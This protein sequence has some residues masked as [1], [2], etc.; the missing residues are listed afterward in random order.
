MSTHV[1]FHGIS[2]NIFLATLASRPVLCPNGIKTQRK[3]IH[4]QRELMKL[5][6]MIKQ[7]RTNLASRGLFVQ[8][9]EH[10]FGLFRNSMKPTGGPIAACT[11]LAM[12]RKGQISLNICGCY[13]FERELNEAEKI[14]LKK[15]IKF[16]NYSVPAEVDT[17]FAYFLIFNLDTFFNLGAGPG[18]STYEISGP[19]YP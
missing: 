3:F 9:Y 1:R 13:W 17:V 16:Q 19:E 7:M 12:D 11:V 18:P 2:W 4:A 15:C 10:Y 14:V 5:I 8:L 6:R